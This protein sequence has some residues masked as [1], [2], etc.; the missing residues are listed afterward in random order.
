M[1]E[2]DVG[3]GDEG[4]IWG[5]LFSH[6]EFMRYCDQETVRYT[7]TYTHKHMRTHTDTKWPC[8]FMIATNKLWIQLTLLLIIHLQS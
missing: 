5:Y 8:W 4:V 6:T 1:S 3:V 7:H 2:K